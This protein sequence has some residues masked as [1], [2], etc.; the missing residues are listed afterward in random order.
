MSL[1]LETIRIEN[2]LI[3]NS[4]Y[5]EMRMKLSCEKIFRKSRHFNLAET[6]RIPHQAKNNVFKC[7]LIYDTE[8][9]QI[10]LL[11]YS[12]VQ[13]RTLKMIENNKISYAFKYADR[14]EI[15][16]LYGLRGKADDILI[17]KNGLVADT[18]RANICFFD[19]EKWV[20]PSTPLLNGTCRQR[21]LDEGE[22]FEAEIK[23]SEIDRF[24]YFLL[25]NAMLGFN[26][27][28]CSSV[29]NIS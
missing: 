14:T 24:Q 1:L 11:P 27:S 9:R 10:E 3:R 20:T 17:I 29:H 5:H 15:N 22:I 26:V 6:I 28:S 23:A 13:V 25:I 16:R 21:L 8:I 7:R 12:P 18:S 19:G 2:G 4:A